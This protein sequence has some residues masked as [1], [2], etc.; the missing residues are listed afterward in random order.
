LEVVGEPYRQENLWRIVGIPETADRVEFDVIAVLVPETQNQ[1]DANAI[2]VWVNGLHVGY[3]S[4]EI[5]A[6]YRPGLDR[7]CAQAPVA[8][9]GTIV[10]GGY[11]GRVAFLGVFLEHDPAD[12]GVAN[13]SL[14]AYEGELRTGLSHAFRTD[15][16]D[17]SYDLSWY[18]E[19]P[20]D[21]RRAIAK[22]TA[23][24]VSDPDPID[25]HFMFVELESRLYRLRDVEDGALGDFDAVCARHDA[26]MVTIRPA[27]LAKFNAMPYL[28]TYRQQCI[29]QQKAK[30]FARGLWW[31]ERGLDLYGED[32]AS[33]DWTDDLGK[34]AK[35]FRARLAAPV[36]KPKTS[37]TT[38]VEVT[39]T[40]TLTCSRCGATWQRVRT[41][42]R[43]PSLCPT[44]SP[45]GV[46]SP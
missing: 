19:L 38:R 26:E 28:E 34:R 18:N 15:R 17:G 43:K 20:T 30:D 2:A 45:P 29:R 22:L 16:Q 27:L 10:G 9:R 33:Q 3:L 5:A 6:R 12:F 42:G 35:T 31:A 32:A 4:R 7:L 13:D 21:T 24:L 39:S 36:S 46:S 37:A 23:L 40:E 44:C 25:R 14:Q 41:R 8:L 11:G 1:Y